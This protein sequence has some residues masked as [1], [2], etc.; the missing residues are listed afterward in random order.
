MNGIHHVLLLIT[1]I[2]LQLVAAILA[3]RLFRIARRHWS[4]FFFSSALLLM[5]VRRIVSLFYISEEQ[6]VSGD[7][8]AE[9]V[10]LLISALMTAGLL[11]ISPLM[12]RLYGMIDAE[13]VPGKPGN[14]LFCELF[15]NISSGV[16]VYEAV[17]KGAD[18][19]IRNVN[20]AAEKIEKTV[21][22][23]L[24]GRRVTEAFPS[25]EEFG[26]LEVMQRVWRSGRPESFPLRY[27]R[28]DRVAG[29]RDNYIYRR[30]SGDLVAVYN[31]VSAQVHLREEL[32]RREQ[33]FRLLYEHAPFPYQALSPDGVIRE[34]N[35]A[36]LTLTGLSR[37][38][39]V[40]RDF[41]ELLSRADRRRFTECLGELNAGRH[42]RGE[43]FQLRRADGQ[44]IGICMD[45]L[46]FCEPPS[47]T[48]QVYCKLHANEQLPAAVTRS[49]GADDALQ[50]AGKLAEARRQL[51]AE[52]LSLLGELTAG[53]AQELNPPLETARNAFALMKE[54]LTPASRYFEFV[55]KASC[56]LERMVE[57]IE[58]IYRFHEPVPAECE[59][60]NLNAMLDNALLLVRAQMHEKEIRMED[61]RA[62]DLPAVNLP[63]GAVMR[64]LLNPLKNAVQALEP[65]GTLTLRTGS[66]GEDGVFVDIED[67][68]PGIPP[69]F[70]PR[71]FEPFKTLGP[72]RHGG[73]G[74]GLGLAIVKHILNA[75][76]GSV[77]V[78]S[79]LNSGTRIRMVLPAAL[80]DQEASG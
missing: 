75:I 38:N 17:D 76:G 4:W 40:G 12:K 20:P 3:W 62:E 49:T 32:E 57:F 34:I 80:P 9:S 7:L 19:I 11:S 43:E 71:V 14:T 13:D 1:S 61:E 74:V 31:D 2:T 50:T 63:P 29:W 26:L 8:Y 35:P 41:G 55:D 77:T 42:V 65:Q 27:Y 33:K 16:V 78:N 53:M 46:A 59:S 28:D 58:R 10:A 23:H 21:R 6:V 54:D 45:A 18:F 22:E 67:D 15:A 72:V 47:G 44:R 66:A 64:V 25:V 52:K 56:E 37:P 24:V 68:G 73:Q 51:L 79:T 48:E 39:A 36:W 30:A 69:E 5:A 60:L 70:L